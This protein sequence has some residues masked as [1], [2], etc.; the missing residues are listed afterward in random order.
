MSLLFQ[1][2]KKKKDDG[3]G[4]EDVDMDESS[5]NSDL[6]VSVM[7]TAT[8]KVLTGDEAPLASEVES[9]LETHPGWEMVCFSIKTTVVDLV[10]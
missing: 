4:V 6:R 2:K 3:S 7:E 5:Q 1:P 8:G 9:W 10:I